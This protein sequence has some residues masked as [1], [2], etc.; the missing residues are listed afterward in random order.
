MKDLLIIDHPTAVDVVIAVC[1]AVGAMY[2][3]AFLRSDTGH[4]IHMQV[5]A[6]IRA[7]EID[8]S[9]LETEYPLDPD[10]EG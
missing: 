2:P 7:R 6:D 3:G 8:W 1:H 10:L 5:D 4:V 9:T